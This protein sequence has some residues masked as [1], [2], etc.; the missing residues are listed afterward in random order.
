MNV[1]IPGGLLEAPTPLVINAITELSHVPSFYK[2][3]MAYDISLG[4]MHELPMPV[5]IE[6]IGEAAKAQ[7]VSY[8]VADINP[9]ESSH[10]SALFLIDPVDALEHGLY[11]V[12]VIDGDRLCLPPVVLVKDEG[13]P[14]VG[15]LFREGRHAR[16]GVAPLLSKLKTTRKTHFH[17]NGRGAYAGDYWCI[18]EGQK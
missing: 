12:S 15:S 5:T 3:E 7:R 16:E 14:L 4:E 9:A 10:G 6:F 18:K 2:E 11:I 13:F 1:I 8:P 17:R